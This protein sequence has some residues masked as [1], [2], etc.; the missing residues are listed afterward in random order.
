MQMLVLALL[1]SRATWA[2][3]KDLIVGV[4]VIATAIL[5]LI[6]LGYNLRNNRRSSYVN[7]V[8]ATRLKWIDEL[9]SNLSRLVALIYECAVAPSSDRAAR[10]ATFREITHLRML[11]RLQLAPGAAPSDQEFEE[12]IE[13]LFRRIQ[14]MSQAQIEAE[15]NNLIAAGQEFLWKEWLKSKRE[16]IYGDPYDRVLYRLSSWYARLD[17]RIEPTGSGIHGS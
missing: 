13:S 2:L 15:L 3:N 7:A 1:P 6:N 9:R 12:R 8:T 5:G 16:A 17:S 4:G 10:Q 11:I 14:G